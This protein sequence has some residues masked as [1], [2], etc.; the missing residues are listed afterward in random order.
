[1]RL[2]LQAGVIMSW[3]LDCSPELMKMITTS[4]DPRRTRTEI[5]VNQAPNDH[6]NTPV[7]G[8]VLT[9]HTYFFVHLKLKLMPTP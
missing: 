3:E 8:T 4:P 6:W 2:Q 1:M 5:M 7:I 9:M